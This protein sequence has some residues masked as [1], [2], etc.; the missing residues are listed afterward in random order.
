MEP[1]SA[2]TTNPP[3]QPEY[4]ILKLKDRG[5]IVTRRLDIV[6]AGKAGKTLARLWAQA[7]V[8]EIGSVLNRSIESSQ[9]AVDFIG[10][11]RPVERIDGIGPLD[12]LMISTSD[13]Y[14]EECAQSVA[15]EGK[16]SPDAVV[17]HCSGSLS[18]DNLRALQQIGCHIGSVH[19]IKSFAEPT[20]AIET[21]DGTFCALEGDEPAIDC[22]Q[23]A[24]AR[25]GG[26]SLEI[27]EA[28]KMIYHAGS[29]FASNYLTAMIY[30]GVRCF[31]KS[32]IPYTQAMEVV[33]QIV[34]G[35]VGNI[36][37]LGLVPALTGPISRGERKIVQKQ[38]EELAQWRPEISD[39][40]R[41]AGVLAVDMAH[42]QN[43]A[44]DSELEEIRQVLKGASESAG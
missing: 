24:V 18:S 12:V 26:H 33:Q 10:E 40:Y 14:I 2:I 42:A 30:A 36:F 25:I 3:I 7:G 16:A 1:R 27:D 44:S 8:F 22:L 34:T 29:V 31:E 9:A 6:G 5:F 28:N 43:G 15:R 4:G 21:F 35:T 41:T 38:L 19:P 11:G 13:R 39:V 37:K 17:F 32:G 23:D 20:L